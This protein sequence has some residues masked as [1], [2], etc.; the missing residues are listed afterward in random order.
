MQKPVPFFMFNGRAEAAVNF[1]LSVFPASYILQMA[2]YDGTSGVHAGKIQLA[3][4][5]IAGQ[6]FMF[7]DSLVEH[8]FSFT[9]SSSIFINC[10]TEDEIDVLYQRLIPDGH[11]LM[12]LGAYPFSKKYAWLTDQFGI[13]WH[14]NLVS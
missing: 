2:H 6:P 14:L 9:P 4:I 1:Y 3:T 13:S 12:P 5:V 7:L 8:A 11:L 10:E